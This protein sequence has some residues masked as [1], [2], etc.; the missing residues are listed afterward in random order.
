[1]CEQAWAQKPWTVLHVRS[2]HFQGSELMPWGQM[3]SAQE[4]LSIL[5]ALDKHLLQ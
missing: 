2:L 1:M 4:S 3:E 5:V